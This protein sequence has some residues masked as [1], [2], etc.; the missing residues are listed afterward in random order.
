MSSKEK[1]D[2]VRMAQN[3]EENIV[4]A[5][6]DGANDVPMIQVLLEKVMFKRE[7]CVVI[8]SL[9]RQLMLGS[10]FPEKWDCIARFRFLK[11]LLVVHGARNFQHSAKVC[12]NYSS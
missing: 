10:G 4:L 8:C 12:L 6:G 1:A 3:N 5:V 9:R 2:T 11:R 7:L